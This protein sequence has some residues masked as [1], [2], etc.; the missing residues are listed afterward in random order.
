M[1]LK[2]K[3]EAI[4]ENLLVGVAY[5]DSAGL[6]VEFKKRQAIIDE[7]GRIQSLLPIENKYFG[8]APAGTWSDDTQLSLAVAE[9]LIESKGFSMESIAQHHI[10]A[11]EQTPVR[12]YKGK[13][14]PRGWGESTWGSV[15]RLKN[16]EAT[17]QN[18]G[19][20]NGEGNG[21]LMK[22]APLA[23]WQT[24]NPSQND[25][26]QIEQLTRMTHAND[27]SVV[28]ALVHRD[29]LRH[30]Y[31]GLV[32]THEIAELAAI[33]AGKYELEYRN[34]G[35]KTSTLLGK[36]AL[37]HKPTPE[38][39]LEIAPRGFQSSET[40]VM[41]YGAYSREPEFPECVF[42]TISLG[43]DTDSI[44]SIVGA[45]AVLQAR[46]VNM[47]SDVDKLDDLARLRRVGKD[48]VATI[49]EQNN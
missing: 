9:S 22:L 26:E 31:K 47:P 42:E 24:L 8:E 28:N 25:D 2:Q 48:L 45:M 40:L 15:L 34:A 3:S 44:A 14:L 30:L 29:I 19:N 4:G 41:A 49:E 17:W 21:V 7:Y 6:P 37:L 13:P 35:N 5:G 11:M 36:L 12:F 46:E 43:G 16:V 39:I 18:S 38:D 33:Y 23:L 27:L 1:S 20:V 10:K 32:K